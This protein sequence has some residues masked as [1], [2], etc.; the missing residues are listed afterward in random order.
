MTPNRAAVPN[1]FA[2]RIDQAGR[3][4]RG[5]DVTASFTMLD[6]EMQQQSYKLSET[7]PGLYEHSA[8][9]LVMVGHWG[10]S[11]AITPRGGHAVHR[12]ARRPGERMRRAAPRRSLRSRL[13]AVREPRAPTATLRATTCSASR[14]SSRST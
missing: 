1:E 10:L 6:M 3:P 9:A 13:R 8:P 2:V 4:V 12:A 14:C 11:F 7:S 5:A